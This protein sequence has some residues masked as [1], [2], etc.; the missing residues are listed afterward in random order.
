MPCGGPGQLGVPRGRHPRR[1]AKSWGPFSTAAEESGQPGS[2]ST[3]PTPGGGAGHRCL[4]H[5]RSPGPGPLHGP[6]ARDLLALRPRR[7]PTPTG[8]VGW[9]RRGVGPLLGRVRESELRIPTVGPATKARSPSRAVCGGGAHRGP[10][11]TFP[12]SADPPGPRLLKPRG[13]GRLPASVP[14]LPLPQDRDA[15]RPPLYSGRGGPRADNPLP[16]GAW[17]QDQLFTSTPSPRRPRPAPPA[18]SGLASQ[19]SSRELSRVLDPPLP[20]ALGW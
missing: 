14:Q 1:P 4:H 19:L 16:G 18:P 2:G 12:A 7:G 11:V 5:G 3:C 13:S 10:H 15:S 8:T 17:Q 9:A 20:P 6:R